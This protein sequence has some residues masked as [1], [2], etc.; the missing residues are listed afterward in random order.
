MADEITF[1][2]TPWSAD[3]YDKTR[4]HDADGT[5]VAQ[6]RGWGHLTG[7]D[8]LN[9]PYS[10]A[11]PIQDGIAAMVLERVNG[12]DALKEQAADLM[13][14]LE[15]RAV[16]LESLERAHALTAR[17]AELET[18]LAAA[19]KRAGD[20]Q[21]WCEEEQKGAHMARV[22]KL[23]Y[24]GMA[25]DRGQEIA[26]LKARAQAAEA[27]VAELERS[28][29]DLRS[30]YN[31]M[32]QDYDFARD[33]AEDA[34]KRVEKLEAQAD[35]DLRFRDRVCLALS[36]ER[37][38]HARSLGINPADVDPVDLDSGPVAAPPTQPRFPTP[39]WRKHRHGG[40]SLLPIREIE[41]GVWLCYTGDADLSATRVNQ[42]DIVDL[43]PG[44][45]T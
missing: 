41:P 1:G 43:E 36:R 31:L 4:F 28:E 24:R 30:S 45:G 19:Q 5:F 2:R 37:Y 11:G 6:V 3:P 13:K 18:S 12:W 16:T 8:A 27:R 29:G 14:Q 33:R 9:L 25:E 34:Q 10:V 42:S 15:Q 39:A 40:G 44:D 32:R 26:R 23:N 22:D 20:W 21:R 35:E 17:V 38:A 7:R